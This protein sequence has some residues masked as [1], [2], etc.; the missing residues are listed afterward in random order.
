MNRKQHGID[1][2]RRRSTLQAVVALTALACLTAGIFGC[3]RSPQNSSAGGAPLS[4]S[5][6]PIAS[7][8][9][10]ASSAPPPPLI[11]AS[12]APDADAVDAADVQTPAQIR[13]FVADE[14]RQI[15]GMPPKCSPHMLGLHASQIETLGK[16]AAPYLVERLTDTTLASPGPCGGDLIGD[17]AEQI[18]DALYDCEG[19]HDLPCSDVDGYCAWNQCLK[20]PGQRARLQASWAGFVARD[21]S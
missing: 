7:A 9:S 16:R 8:S 17:Y 1:Q 20:R 5:S 14:L 19:P 13:K 18:L 2:A 15:N 12:T 21:G 11:A 6:L 4:G 10:P 3:S